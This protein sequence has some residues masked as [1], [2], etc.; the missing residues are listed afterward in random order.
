[1]IINNMMD[2]KT[3]NGGEVTLTAGAASTTLRDPIINV[4]S[5]LWLSPQTSN[6]A[7]A[8]GTTYFSAPTSGAIVINHANNGQ[9]DRTFAYGVCF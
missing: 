9:T 2:G 4:N 8:L 7:A 3:N 1:M 6:A 5:R